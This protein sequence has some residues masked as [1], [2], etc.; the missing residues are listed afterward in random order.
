M[1]IPSLPH[2]TRAVV[3]R[4]QGLLAM[5]GTSS[6]PAH[7]VI[8]AFREAGA[9]APP[10]A[11]RFHPSTRLQEA[12]FQQLLRL[13]IICQ[14]TYGRYYLDERALQAVQREGRLPWR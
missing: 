1:N 6:L 14:P 7:R 4:A 11:Q 8:T 2:I 9:L 12:A 10:R 13:G 3:N 5:L